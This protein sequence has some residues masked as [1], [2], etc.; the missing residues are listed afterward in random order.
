MK[1]IKG[2]LKVFERDSLFKFLEDIAK[3]DLDKIAEYLL[4]NPEIDLIELF[5]NL[6]LE[7]SR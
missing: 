7:G 6:T 1:S 4:K 5:E 2:E 3:I